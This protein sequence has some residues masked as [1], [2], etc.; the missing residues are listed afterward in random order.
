MVKPAPHC[1]EI[2]RYSKKSCLYGQWIKWFHEIW[3]KNIS[4]KMDV[5]LTNKYWFNM[6]RGCEAKP[7]RSLS[8][9]E[10]WLILNRKKAHKNNMIITVAPRLSLGT[11]I[12][13]LIDCKKDKFILPS[14]ILTISHLVT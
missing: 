9:Y 2:Y 5:T 8:K 13:E 10:G 7:R 1:S 12:N 14:E 3:W 6:T 11:N 4:D